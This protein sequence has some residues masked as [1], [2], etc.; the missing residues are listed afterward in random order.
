MTLQ[1]ESEIMQE[2]DRMKPY[3][4]ALDQELEKLQESYNSISA[5]LDHNKNKR[6]LQRD[7][8]KEQQLAVHNRML[9]IMSARGYMY[10]VAGMN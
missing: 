5:T 2:I 9:G 6:F 7:F 3:F 1:R 4:D 8:Y 10:K